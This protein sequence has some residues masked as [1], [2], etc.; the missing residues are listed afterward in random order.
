MPVWARSNGKIARPW[1][2]TLKSVLW[3]SRSEAMEKESRKDC[4]F[5][6]RSYAD[7]A[8]LCGRDSC[9]RCADGRWVER[10]EDIVSSFGP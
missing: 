1:N 6:G 2:E 3:V 8:E 4:T 5:E 7:G 10:F 9:Q